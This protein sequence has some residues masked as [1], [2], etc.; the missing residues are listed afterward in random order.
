[1]VLDH[2]DLS[3]I[4]SMQKADCYFAHAL[5]CG[6]NIFMSPTLGQHAPENAPALFHLMLKL[7]KQKLLS[8][9][10]TIDRGYVKDGLELIFM[11]FIKDKTIKNTSHY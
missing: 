2:V 4:G 5:N 6:K 3:G 9:K 10:S 7:W 11:Q 8:Q 1:M